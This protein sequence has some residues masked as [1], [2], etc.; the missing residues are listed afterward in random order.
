M[1]GSNDFAYVCRTIRNPCA[2]DILVLAGAELQD[3]I[4]R[5]GQHG[6]VSAA[7]RLRVNNARLLGQ[8][9]GGQANGTMSGS[10]TASK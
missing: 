9:Y 1:P 2:A 7:N 5:T 6:D 10:H 3:T 4:E 8:Q